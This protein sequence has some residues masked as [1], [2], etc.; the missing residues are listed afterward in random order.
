MFFEL[1]WQHLDN[2]SRQQFWE[3]K[4]MKFSENFRIESIEPI[5]FNKYSSMIETAEKEGTLESE[6]WP[7]GETLHFIKTKDDARCVIVDRGSSNVVLIKLC[8]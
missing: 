4:Q 6:V 2:G 8:K 1:Q 3:Q 5:D 7:Y